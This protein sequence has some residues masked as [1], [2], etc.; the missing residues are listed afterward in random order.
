MTE[1]NKIYESLVQGPDDAIGAFAYVLYKQHKVEWMKDIHTRHQRTPTG[2][3]VEFFHAENILPGMIEAYRKRGEALAIA[4]LEA[5]LE[6]KIIEIEESV[7]ASSLA[8]R[9]E[10]VEMRLDD[11]KGVKGWFR[12]IGT[13]VMV[14]VL[15][16]LVIGAVIVGSKLWGDFNSFLEGKYGGGAAGQH[17]AVPPANGT[18]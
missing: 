13:N 3:E 14:N 11:R 8:K 15:T 17:Q 4:F 10:G 2:Q 5:G 1:H 18:K 6:E 16:I 9:F 12:D 7:K